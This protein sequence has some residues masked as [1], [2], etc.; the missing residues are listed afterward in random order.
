MHDKKDPPVS[1]PRRVPL[2]LP[3]LQN[4]TEKPKGVFTFE[5]NGGSETT[6]L[7]SVQSIMVYG[8]SEVTLDLD[9]IDKIARSGV[10]IIIHRRNLGQ[11]IYIT[12]GLRPDPDDTVSY[13]LVFQKQARKRRHIARQLLIAKLR[14]CSWLVPPPQLPVFASIEQESTLL[15]MRIQEDTWLAR[16]DSTYL[17]QARKFAVASIAC[18]GTFPCKLPPAVFTP[19]TFGRPFGTLGAKEKAHVKWTLSLAGDEGFEPPITGP[20]PVALPLG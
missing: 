20:E 1:R 6:R 2:W 12:G 11:P 5:Y 15:W 7:D 3:Y 9:I 8:D 19:I 14:S 17:R 18:T 16:R 4:I 13:Q 10:P